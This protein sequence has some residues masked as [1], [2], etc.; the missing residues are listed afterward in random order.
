VR[1]SLPASG[2]F[3]DIPPRYYEGPETCVFAGPLEEII[4]VDVRIPG[5]PPSPDAIAIALAALCDGG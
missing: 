2:D 4:P 3:F 5:C 1:R